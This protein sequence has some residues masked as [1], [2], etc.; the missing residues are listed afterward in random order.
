MDGYVVEGRV[1]APNVLPKVHGSD[2]RST[3]YTL[4]IT[5]FRRWQRRRSGTKEEEMTE[6]VGVEGM[7]GL[8]ER[9]GRVG[10]VERG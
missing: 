2:I 10:R 7:E 8:L 3:I 6:A 4:L 1:E 5:S 9:V